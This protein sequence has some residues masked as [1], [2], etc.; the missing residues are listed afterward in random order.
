ME[1]IDIKR[2][3]KTVSNLKIVIA[4]IM[5]ISIIMRMLLFFLYVSTKI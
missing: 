5:V 1:E 3:L 2:F 4:I